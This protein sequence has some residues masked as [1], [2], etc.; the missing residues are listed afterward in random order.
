MSDG[1]L[2]RPIRRPLLRGGGAASRASGRA[3]RARAI[4]FWPAPVLGVVEEAIG[5]DW[6]RM[7]AAL[8]AIPDGRWT[9]F[10]DLAALAGTA[11]QAFGNHIVANVS[12]PPRRPCQRR[13]AVA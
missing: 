5:F 8:A 13:T 4:T 11:A 10:G 9:T 6:T 7:H 3:R 12:L 2:W 1:Y